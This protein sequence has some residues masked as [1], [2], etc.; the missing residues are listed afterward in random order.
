MVSCLSQFTFDKCSSP[1][2]NFKN[3]ALILFVDMPLEITRQ[4]FYISAYIY[5]L[6]GKIFDYYSHLKVVH[7]LL[8]LCVQYTMPFDVLKTSVCGHKNYADQNQSQR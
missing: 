6:I 2:M 7:K 3:F 4:E 1:K 5:P 8:S